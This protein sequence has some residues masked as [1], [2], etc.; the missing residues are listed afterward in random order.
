MP[1]IRVV[2]RT[3]VVANDATFPSGAGQ[4]GAVLLTGGAVPASSPGTRVGVLLDVTV[5]GAG[6]IVRIT[7]FG[8][9]ADANQWY[10][11]A[12]L[13]NG[14]DITPTTQTPVAEGNNIHYAEV[15]TSLASQYD[16]L[17]AMITSIAGAA[18]SVSV[19]FL[20]DTQS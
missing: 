1:A 13:N 3:A 15:L 6:G 18:A 4:A 11:V 16:R 7:I 9:R 17:Y 2:A 10:T 19:A 12:R 14:A 8:Y 20:I 5:G